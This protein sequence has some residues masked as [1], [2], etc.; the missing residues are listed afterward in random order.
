MDQKG[1]LS[2]LLLVALLPVSWKRA[3]DIACLVSMVAVALMLLLF[4]RL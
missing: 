1:A 3:A 2:V 4:G